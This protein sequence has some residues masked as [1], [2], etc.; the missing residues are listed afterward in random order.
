[1]SVIICCILENRIINISIQIKVY[2][3]LEAEGRPVT[4]DQNQKGT[5]TFGYKY[6]NSRVMDFMSW[7]MNTQSFVK[8]S[9]VEYVFVS[10]SLAV[11]IAK[12][13]PAIHNH[14]IIVSK[15]TNKFEYQSCI[16]S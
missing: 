3:Y 1:M 14:N 16:Y 13:F 6:H 9:L 10:L 7:S 4:W 8:L 5:V 15:A 11:I 2:S 12:F